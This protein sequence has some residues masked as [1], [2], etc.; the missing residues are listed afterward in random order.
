MVLTGGRASQVCLDRNLGTIA[1][2]TPK[3]LIPRSLSRSPREPDTSPAGVPGS[4][5]TAEIELKL[6]NI[7][8]LGKD[9][10]SNTTKGVIGWFQLV[11]PIGS[12]GA[13]VDVLT[14]ELKLGFKLHRP[15]LLT[16]LSEGCATELKRRP[17]R[18]IDILN[19][20]QADY[21]P[22]PW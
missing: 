5:A 14:G 1:K 12:I 4:E 22:A 21:T 11:P 15:H 6:A 16:D 10:P 13:A 2:K 20:D 17:S 19:E 9:G 7:F 18:Y 8:L 3:R